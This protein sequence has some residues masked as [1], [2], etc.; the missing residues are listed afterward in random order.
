M[1]DPED[2]GRAIA[3]LPEDLDGLLALHGVVPKAVRLLRRA[4]AD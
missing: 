1:A 3:D 4:R 2:R